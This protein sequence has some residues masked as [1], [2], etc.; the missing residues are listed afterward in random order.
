MALARLLSALWFDCGKARDP[1]TQVI[2]EHKRTSPA[3]DGSQFA[4]F[5]RFIKRCPSGARNHARLRDVVSKR[6]IH[7]YF[8]T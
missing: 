6:S 1:G 2:G 8:A 3:L 5:D 7:F 4:R